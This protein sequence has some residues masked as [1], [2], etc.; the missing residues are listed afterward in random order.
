MRLKAAGTCL[1]DP[2][3]KRVLTDVDHPTVKRVWTV[4]LTVVQKDSLCRVSL[5]F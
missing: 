1:S 4:I 2:T 5:P 3:V